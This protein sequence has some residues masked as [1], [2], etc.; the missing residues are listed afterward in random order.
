MADTKFYSIDP[1]LIVLSKKTKGA[2][3]KISG[4]YN[5]RYVFIDQ[6]KQETYFQ[7]T[8]ENHNCEDCP[9]CQEKIKLV[10]WKTRYTFYYIKGYISLYQKLR[11]VPDNLSVESLRKFLGLDIVTLIS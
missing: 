9:L 3:V 1:R 4:W 5:S 6:E 8:S 2:E 10:G 7:V 11:G